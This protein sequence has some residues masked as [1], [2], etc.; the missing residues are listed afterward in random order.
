[1]I[2]PL[3]DSYEQTIALLQKE[4]TNTKF[5][6]KQ[7][8]EDCEAVIHENDEL[9]EQLQVK[10]RELLK[11]SKDRMAHPGEGQIFEGDGAAAEGEDG[12]TSTA[13]I[14]MELKNKAHL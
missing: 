2:G 13:Q 5:K 3:L 10:N 14:I 8:M 4:I 1:M 11:I 7:Q 6:F 9:K 12:A